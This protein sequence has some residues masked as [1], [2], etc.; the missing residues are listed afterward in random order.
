MSYQVNEV[1]SDLHHNL[2]QDSLGNLKKVINV[3]AVASSIDNILRTYP[4]ERFFLPEFGSSLH[5]IVFENTNKTLLD[6][7]SR[8][9]KETIERWDDRI[10]VS[11]VKFFADP[12]QGTISL[13][14]S[15]MVRGFGQIF[16]YSIPI[17]GE[18]S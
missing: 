3:D 16:T 4:G 13:T 7:I 12:D 6:Y 17:K 5:G 11:E 1:W 8:D 2:I 9:V 10:L 14:L 18:I 15:Y